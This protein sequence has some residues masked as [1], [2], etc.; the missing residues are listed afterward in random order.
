MSTFAYDSASTV[1]VVGLGKIGLPLAAHIASRGHSVIGCDIQPSVVAAVN[2]GQ[3]PIREEPGLPEAVAAAVRGGRLRATIDTTTAVTAAS[4]VVVI[5]PLAVDA[6]MQPDFGAVDSATRSIAA[7]L[8]PGTLVLYETTLPVGTT[9]RRIARLLENGGQLRAGLDFGLAFSP[10]RV[11]S[12]RVF[13]DLR[14]YPKIVGGID[15]LSTQHASEFYRAVL[16][17]EVLEV[18]NS[19][20]AEFAKLA[21]TTYRD[22]NFALA[23]QLAVYAA[24]RGVDTLAAFRVANTQPFSHLHAP[25]IGIGG[26]CIPVYPYF[27][28]ADGAAD[29]LE[30]LR[31][32]RQTNDG[33]AAV[34]VRLLAEQLGSLAGLRILIL[35]LA[36][37]E[38]VKELAFS[39]APRIANLLRAQGAEVLA[40]DPLFTASELARIPATPVDL[41]QPLALDAIIIQA[42]HEQYRDLDWHQF[43]GLRLVLDGRGGMDPE[44]LADTGA[45]YL[46]IGKPAARRLVPELEV[47]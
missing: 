34:A 41:Y 11:Y 14:R 2:I 32:A 9:A 30:L 23:N 19:E 8:R 46:A 27:L 43:R 22:V 44:Q 6:N 37:R 33:M 16:D 21:E 15:P 28:L 7:G 20:T 40:H 13:E 18:A 38:N 45:T 36:Y 42:F 25:N 10:E 47:T 12:G 31:I 29:E 5:V 1:V 3:S 26:H 24:R 39:V 17:C 4:V 35:G